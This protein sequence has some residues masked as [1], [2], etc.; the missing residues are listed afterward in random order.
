MFSEC[1]LQAVGVVAGEY[2]VAVVAPTGALDKKGRDIMEEL[3]ESP[4]D[5]HVLAGP[6]HPPSCTA[7][8]SQGVQLFDT[9]AGTEAGQE[10]TLTIEPRDAFG[11]LTTWDPDILLH[12]DA[13]G[14]SQVH[15]EQAGPDGDIYT[16]V[17]T[18]AGTYLVMLTSG[19]AHLK[20]WPKILQVVPGP[21]AAVMCSPKLTGLQHISLQ[22]G[23]HLEADQKV[24]LFT[25]PFRQ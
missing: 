11:N 10:V 13:E 6:V 1:S 3:Y 20:G 9:T 22:A 7:Y 19:A 16:A 17:L 5:V 8:F 2:S 15:F 23:H 4:I 14:P 12:V 21:T 25:K 24:G 18:V